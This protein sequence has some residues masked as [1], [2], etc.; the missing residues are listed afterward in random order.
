MPSQQESTR[1]RACTLEAKEVST[2][3]GNF[4]SVAPDGTA[5]TGLR[6][7]QRVRME[8]SSLADVPPPS[9]PDAS[10]PS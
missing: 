7:G 10:V 1:G 5:G 6:K 4:D 3:A 2:G 9:P 8:A